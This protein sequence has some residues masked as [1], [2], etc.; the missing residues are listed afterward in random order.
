MIDAIEE[1]LISQDAIEKRVA[2][3]GQTLSQ[4]YAGRK[5]LLVGILKGAC[6]YFMDII[7]HMPIPLE[8]DFMEVSSYGEA[9]N[10]SGQIKIIKDI[11]KDVKGRDI[12]FVEDIIDTGQTLK[13]L[14]AL[15]LKRHAASVKTTALLN[16]QDRRIVDFQA[17][18]VGFEI[19]N[20]FVVGYGMDFNEQYR[21]LPYI[22]VLKPK[23]YQ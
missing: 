13:E 15:M 11:T 16:K 10:S 6:P 8:I 21:N 23:C 3:L 7:R 18:Y 14:Q 12:L 5:P 9:T 17:D 2:E 1:V 19:P 4:E 22:G 20:A